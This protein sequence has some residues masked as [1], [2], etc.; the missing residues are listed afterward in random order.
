MAR[1]IRVVSCPYLLYMYVNETR[2]SG[3][4]FTGAVR[5]FLLAPGSATVTYRA[6][7]MCLNCS[8]C[9]FS[10]FCIL[11]LASGPRALRE[12]VAQMLL[13]YVNFN[14]CIDLYAVI[15]N[16]ADKWSERVT[17][18]AHYSQLQSTTLSTYQSVYDVT[19][20]A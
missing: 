13:V 14:C 12:L 1:R 7:S 9:W 15:S 6:T 4:F 17:H 16:D 10:S 19:L 2:P 5:A 20:I 11:S 18:C 3:A 8:F